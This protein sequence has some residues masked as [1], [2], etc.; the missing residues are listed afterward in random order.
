ME[1][2]S[3]FQRRQSVCVHLASASVTKRPLRSSSK[4]CDD[5]HK[6]E[7]TSSAK[8]NSGQKPK[9]SERDHRTL[10]RTVSKN[11]STA[12][13]VTA[14][15]WKTISTWTVWQELHKSNTHSRAST[16]NPLITENNAKRHKRWHDD[17][18]TWMSDDWKY[19]MWS[20]QLSFTLFPT[21]GW[22]YV[23]RTSSKS[24]ILNAWFKLWNMEVDLWWFGQQYLGILLVK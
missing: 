11:D 7:K 6:W 8:R 23:W 10:K 21:S 16:A 14:D 15:I 18:K 17:H 3:D 4:D 9:L 1:N 2:L 12:A 13:K 5:M 20:D 22:V 19:V 24:I